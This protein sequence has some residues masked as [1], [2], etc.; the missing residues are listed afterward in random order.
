M[1]VFVML[2]S[3]ITME[4]SAQKMTALSIVPSTEGPGIAFRQWTT[5]NFGWGIEGLTNW[6]FGNIIG[7]GRL[8]YSFVNNE[9]SKY[10][11][12][13]SVGYMSINERDEGVEFSASAPSAAVGLG[14]EWFV[15]N[16]N[17][18]GIGL[19]LGYQYGKADYDITI[20][21]PM[22]GPMSSSHTYKLPALYIGATLSYYFNR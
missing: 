6:E 2:A 9:K 18:T 15:G 21:I 13:I 11:G 16:T 22:Y 7:R 12:L 17:S 19:E 10:Y 4:V 20:D 1:I 5:S 14:G 3:G 8:M